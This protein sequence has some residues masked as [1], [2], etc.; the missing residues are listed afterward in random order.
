V[1]ARDLRNKMLSPFSLSM[2]PTRTPT[3]AAPAVIKGAPA[4]REMVREIG[5]TDDIIREKENVR[6][7]MLERINWQIGV[8]RDNRLADLRFQGIPEGTEA[9]ERSVRVFDRQMI[10]ARLQVEGAVG[11]EHT[12]LVELT[13]H[14]AD[15]HNAIVVKEFELD[16]Q[17]RQFGNATEVQVFETLMALGQYVNTIRNQSMQ[18]ILAERSQTTNEV[19]VLMRGGTVNI[20]QFQQFQSGKIGETPVMDAVYRS[21]SMDMQKW[22]AQSQQQGQ[23]FGGMMGMVGNLMPMMMGMSDRRVKTDIVKVSDDARGFG[24]YLWRYVWDHVGTVR[25]GVMAQEVRHIRGAVIELPG[26]VLAVNYGVLA[27]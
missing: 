10:D 20:P 12:R 6:L 3:P 22:Q 9:W 4:R 17:A 15:F 21:A 19:S 11:Q 27:Q 13:R 26:G 1:L 24:W 14:K 7:K 18:E 8:D 2:L 25:Y 23:M 16:L 5:Q